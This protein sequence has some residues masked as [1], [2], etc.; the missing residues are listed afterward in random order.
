MEKSKYRKM[1]PVEHVLARPEIYVGSM[2]LRKTFEY[3]QTSNGIISG[4]DKGRDIGESVDVVDGQ[5]AVDIADETEIIEKKEI[6]ISPAFVRIFIEPLSNAI[7]NLARSNKEGIKMTKISVEIDRETGL[8]TITNDGAGIPIE[9]HPEYGCYNHTMIFGELFTGSNYNDKEDR[10]EI[11]GLNGV[12]VKL[13]CIF[14]KLFTVEGVDNKKKFTQTWKKNMS[15]VSEPLIEKSKLKKGYTKISFIPDFSRFGL[16]GYNENIIALFK[17]YLSDTAM[18]T[19][20]RVSFNGSVIPVKNIKDYAGLYSLSGLEEYFTVETENCRVLLTSNTSG[21]FE[22]ISFANGIYTPLGGTHVDSWTETLLRPIV[23]K[24]NKPK[25]PS[26]NI[27]DVK[28][29]FRLFVVASVINP[30]FESQSKLK[31]EEPVIK[32]SIDIKAIKKILKWKVIQKIE[33]VIKGKELSSLKKSERKK[34]GYEKVKGLEPANNEGGKKGQDCTLILVEGDSAKTYAIT[35]IQ[36]GAFGKV[37]RDWFGIMTLTGKLLNCRNATISSIEKNK[38]IESIVKALNLQY[39]L[40]YQLEEN[41]LKLRYGRVMAIT[42]ADVD[43]IH[44]SGLLQN[45]FH[46]LFPSLLLRKEAFYTSMQTPIVRIYGKTDRF[47]YDENEYKE[48][49]QKNPKTTNKKYYKGLGTSNDDE[50]LETFAKKIVRF[51]MDEKAKDSFDKAFHSK[52]ANL[53]KQWISTPPKDSVLKWKGNKVEQQTITFSDFIDTELIK[54]SIDDCSRSIPNIMDGLKQG[55]RKVLYTIFKTPSLKHS[56]KTMKVAQVA[57]LVAYET[58]YHHG[59][60]NLHGTIIGMAQNFVGSNNIPLLVRDGAFG[61]RNAGGKDAASGR[62]P[63]TK[64]EKITRHIFHP[65]DD[66][67][68]TYTE[69]NGKTVEPE[70]FV[71]IIPM[72]LVNGCIAGIGT[73]WSC[74]VPNYN[75]R[76]IIALIK[77]WLDKKDSGEIT[78]LQDYSLDPYYEGFTGKIEKENEKKY[79][80]YGIL[81]NNIISELPIKCWTNDYTE[82]LESL[83]EEKKIMS[84]KNYSTP[85]RIRYELKPVKDTVLSLEDLKLKTCISISNMMLFD[86]TKKIRKFSTAQEILETFCEIRYGYYVKRKVH[87]LEQ[88]ERLLK[89]LANKKRFLEYIRDGNIKLFVKTN[90]KKESKKTEEIITELDEMKFDRVDES[91]DYLFKLE[92]MH[93]T[94]EKINKLENEI[95][96]NRNERDLLSSTKESN[97]WRNDLEELEKYL[98]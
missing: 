77:V 68:L 62:Y 85:T 1:N 95:V 4:G 45:M 93:I 16:E 14:S 7:D 67:L 82:H 69:D 18:I 50:I 76:D 6:E 55:H 86:E 27:S 37:G 64:L 78:T 24:F 51:E 70:F 21:E 30:R 26:I 13:T 48:Y 43:G 47:F 71:P 35:G 73:G 44:I 87:K 10:F 2:R 98:K 90:G 58:E 97:I 54:Y 56:G 39:D 89:L 3:I 46:V 91:F 59:E 75:P 42:D 32:S 83:R 20:L 84:Y 25:K 74:S 22:T 34:R 57:G 38:V 29:F 61:T 49:L 12:G 33:N 72:I 66:I 53:R 40:D 23:E 11:S 96:N 65:D 94:A 79:A 63:L 52:M 92:I 9:K 15:K 88:L 81:K 60:Q 8:T 36:K 17:R 80:T 41:F 5:D 28:K 31:L 19:R